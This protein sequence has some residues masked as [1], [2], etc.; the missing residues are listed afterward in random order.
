MQRPFY[1]LCSPGLEKNHISA[2]RQNLKNMAG[3]FF[4]INMMSLNV[5][6]QLS[7]FK[8]DRGV[9]GDGRHAPKSTL[10]KIKK[11][12]CYENLSNHDSLNFRFVEIN[13]LMICQINGS[14][15]LHFYQNSGSNLS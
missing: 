15:N 4:I 9:W 2:P 3:N 5:K 1:E 12:W 7:S 8:T 13:E 10:V 14:S 6:F 11:L